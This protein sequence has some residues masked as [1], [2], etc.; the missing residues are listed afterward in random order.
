MATKF[1]SPVEILTPR[2]PENMYKIFHKRV[3]QD[4][5]NTTH[6]STDTGD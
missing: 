5:K 1:E 2:S 4:I 3:M 6:I